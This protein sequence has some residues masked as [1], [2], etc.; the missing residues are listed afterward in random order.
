MD[1]C[2]SVFGEI[3][4]VFVAADLFNPLY[5]YC[6]YNLLSRTFFQGPYIVLWL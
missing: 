3:Q 2:P 5:S 1:R 6:N 4:R